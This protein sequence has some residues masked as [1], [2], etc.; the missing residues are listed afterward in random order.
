MLTYNT[1]IGAAP[2]ITDEYRQ[3]ATTGLRL[4]SPYAYSSQHQDILNALG[5]MNAAKYNVQAD[6]TNADFNTR[7][8]QA[9]RDT[10]LAGLQQM[11]QAKQQQSDLLNAQSNMRYGLVSNLLS[12]LF[13]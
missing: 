4:K 5:D 2:P 9:Q 6:Q 12:G 10:A 13:R 1:S 3:Q 11:S 7:R 8:L